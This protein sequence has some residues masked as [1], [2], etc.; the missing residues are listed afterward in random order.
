MN[1]EQDEDSAIDTIYNTIDNLLR[2]KNFTACSEL[3]Q[4]VEPAQLSTAMILSFLIATRRAKPHLDR[5]CFVEKIKGR[6]LELEG[7]H[8]TTRLLKIYA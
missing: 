7:E 3:L 5:D 8:E 6:L 2:A 4:Q 1:L